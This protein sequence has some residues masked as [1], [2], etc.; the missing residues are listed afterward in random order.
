MKLS[1]QIERQTRAL[2]LKHIFGDELNPQEFDALSELT[3]KKRAD[4]HQVIF[5]Q[6]DTADAV[7]VILHGQLRIS[8]ATADGREITLAVMREGDM[9]GE[10]GFLDGRERSADAT[11]MKETIY[12][13]LDQ[14]TLY[15]YLDKNP[16]LYRALI[17]MLCG[18]LRKT[19]QTLTNV[20]LLTVNGRLAHLIA[21]MMDNHGRKLSDGSIEITSSQ[22]DLAAR[23]ATSRQT[24][25]KHLRDWEKAGYVKLQHSRVA[26]YDI[27]AILESVETE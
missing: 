23:I 22:S 21:D 19:N 14:Q 27:D 12:L 13:Q 3:I 25:N 2:L 18:R 17:N 11:A 4:R 5:Q 1:A 26:V 24:V 20:S 7:M 9:F 16:K 6:G 15:S 8:T 10:M